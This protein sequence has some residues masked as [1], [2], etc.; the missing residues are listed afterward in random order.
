V[1]LF[2][3]ATARPLRRAVD[4]GILAY[5]PNTA[6]AAQAAAT[7]RMAMAGRASFSSRTLSAVLHHGRS[8]DLSRREREVDM[9][10]RNGLTP[11][12]IAA[13]LQVS[14]STVRTYAARVRAKTDTTGTAFGGVGEPEI[15]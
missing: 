10:I 14:E 7:I 15:Q 12:E 3:P 1:V 6:D 5:V 2:G 13:G 9:L 11:V 8:V 4:A